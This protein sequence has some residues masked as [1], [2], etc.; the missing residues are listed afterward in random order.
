M[1]DSWNTNFD[2]CLFLPP[3]EPV[4]CL[5]WNPHVAQSD[6][7]MLAAASWSHEIRVWS[8]QQSTGESELSYVVPL[9]RPML[10]CTFPGPTSIVSG[11]L[12]SSV[13]FINLES[14]QYRVLLKFWAPVMHVDTWDA[15]T[16][17]ATSWDKR[18]KVYDARM[19]PPTDMT[20]HVVFQTTDVPHAAACAPPLYSVATADRMITTWD[21]RMSKLP[22][23]RA[24][25][26]MELQTRSVALLPGQTGLV[27]SSIGGKFSV[28]YFPHVSGG[29]N[30]ANAGVLANGG[31]VTHESPWF[32][33]HATASKGSGS[34]DWKNVVVHDAHLDRKHVSPWM[35]TANSV[36]LSAGS[37]TA[38][39]AATTTKRL[40]GG[41]GFSLKGKQKNVIPATTHETKTMGQPSPYRNYSVAAHRI[42][43]DIYAIN[44][45][46]W[47]HK[48]NCFASIGSD[49][50]FLMWDILTHELLWESQRLE[51]KVTKQVFSLTRGAFSPNGE[52]LAY[53][54]G[55]DFSTASSSSTAEA[56]PTQILLHYL[57]QNELTVDKPI[58]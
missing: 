46:L 49:G 28:V 32:G 11:G 39:A 33:H 58:N 22:W 18:C 4:T 7:Q 43:H 30:G 38:T 31:G 40:T 29:G 41:K 48:Y 37:T 52:L 53:A 8:V 56:P 50:C 35:G 26:E 19:A 3:A 9:S 23:H 10:T 17:L 16:I 14:M 12:D 55:N 45:V 6:M 54:V 24:S 15:N 5:A 2:T 42:G 13:T 21:L 36:E 1:D 34:S 47:N 44:Q 20:S 51:S 27:A 25:T 57:R